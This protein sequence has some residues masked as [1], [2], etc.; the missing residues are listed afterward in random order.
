MIR[1][2]Y[3]DRV[4]V[5]RNLVEHRTVIRKHLNLIGVDV[6][7]LRPLFHRRVPIFIHIDRR[8]ELFSYR[9]PEMSKPS[10]AA[11]NLHEPNFF[12]GMLCVQNVKRRDRKSA[13]RDCGT[14]EK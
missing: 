13:C 10:P 7:G 11:P 2:R 5:L 12:S 8:D 1:R 14:L 6:L 3:E 9:G 4:H